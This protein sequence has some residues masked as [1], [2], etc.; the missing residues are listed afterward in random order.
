[1]ASGNIFINYRRSVNLRD[2][3]LLHTVLSRQFGESRVFLDVSDLEGGDHWPHKLERQVDAS[4]V[5]AVLIGKD[6]A[7]IKN[8]KGERRLENPNDYVRL[9][10]ARAFSREISVLPVLIDGATMPDVAKLP[11]NLLELTSQQAMLLRGESFKDDAA[12]IA[13]Q[14]KHLIAKAKKHRGVNRTLAASLAAAALLAGGAGGW[15]VQKQDTGRR[16]ETAEDELRKA[17]NQATREANRAAQLVQQVLAREGD[18]AAALKAAREAETDKTAAEKAKADAIEAQQRA[19]AELRKAR[20]EAKA[21]A[22]EAQKKAEAGLVRA[23]EEAMQQAATPLRTAEQHWEKER[24]I[25]KRAAGTAAIEAQQRAAA[26]LVK[27]QVE[28]RRAGDA[29]KHLSD[30]LSDERRKHEEAHS[31]AEKALKLANAKLRMLDAAGYDAA[32]KANTMGAYEQYRSLWPQGEFIPKAEQKI[33]E[34]ETIVKLCD[35]LAANPDDKEKKVEV[36]VRFGVLQKNSVKAVEACR[37]ARDRLPTTQR[38]QYQLAR[39]YKAADQNLA[40]AEAIWKELTSKGYN[41][42]F[43]NLGWL[44][45]D[46]FFVNWN[47]QDFKD[48]IFN[49]LEGAKKKTTGGYDEPWNCFHLPWIS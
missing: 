15:W 10:I 43:D 44:Y 33:R 20:D 28:A 48:A 13:D 31:Q 36:G 35:E 41:A 14:L 47:Q 9:E 45:L 18:V 12:K 27:W 24:E 32:Q 1:M 42:A 40:E 25:L 16:L 2:A 3:Q 49:F 34:V 6:W 23:K 22:A 17:R 19:V 11:T 46:R 30:I 5:M 37:N 26:D 7:E 39:A 29:E 38:L 4:S 8:G 21:D